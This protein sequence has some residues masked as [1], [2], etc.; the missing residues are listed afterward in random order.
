MGEK[1]SANKTEKELQ[2]R[3]RCK[4]NMGDHLGNQV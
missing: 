1:K 4:T 3:E 2:V